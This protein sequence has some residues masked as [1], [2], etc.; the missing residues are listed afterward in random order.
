[1]VNDV[2][3]VGIGD[4]IYTSRSRPW[5]YRELDSSIE[6]IQSCKCVDNCQSKSCLCNQMSENRWYGEDG[7]LNG[8]ID[9]ANQV[10]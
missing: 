8:K 1:M 3:N 7:R 4:W 6:S 10:N 5:K 2:D 9:L